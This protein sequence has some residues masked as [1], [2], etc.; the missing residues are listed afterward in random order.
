[1]QDLTLI[2]K[3][4]AITT[5]KAETSVQSDSSRF[6]SKDSDST[7]MLDTFL[8]YWSN[9]TD[10]RNR[11][12]RNYEY[13]IGNQ[14]Y[15]RINVIDK[16]GNNSTVTEDYYIRSNGRI[17]F[18]QNILQQIGKNIIGQYEL[19]PSQSIVKSRN[20]EDQKRSDM[21]SGALDEGM[22][23]NNIQILEPR[24]L[25]A[26]L[27]SGMIIS[28]VGWEYWPE[29][30]RSDL[31]YALV[32][33]TNIAFNAYNDPRGEGINFIGEIIDASIETV[34]AAFAKT[35]ADEEAIRSMFPN[36]GNKYS[37]QNSSSRTGTGEDVKNNDF[38]TPSD[39]SLCRVYACWEKRGEWRMREHDYLQGTLKVTKRTQKQIDIENTE[40]LRFCEQNGVQPDPKLH[41]IQSERRFEEFWYYKF[42]TANYECLAEGESPFEHQSHPYII[43]A[44]PLLNGRIWGYNEMLIDSQRQINRL[45]SLQDAILGGS[46]KNLLVIPEEALK[47]E[48]SSS[49]DEIAEEH[50]RIN[51]TIVLDLKNGGALPQTLT[52][53]AASLGIKDMVGSYITLIMNLSGISGAIQG[54]KANAGTP[55]SQ[56]AQEAQNSQINVLDVMTTFKFHKQLRDSKA[57]RVIRQY[58]PD[59]PLASNKTNKEAMMYKAEEVRAIKDV[60]V[61]VS[62]S[63]DTPIYRS[64]MQDKL[65]FF[66]EKGLMD[67]ETMAQLSDESWAEP[68]LAIIEKRKAE[69]PGQMTP[70]MAAQL[71]GVQGQIQQSDTRTP[72]QQQLVANTMR[73]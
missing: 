34:L 36:G 69:Q 49:L 64:I 12:N 73:G 28:K 2:K 72:E 50:S 57:L 21:L 32:N 68:L 52:G 70:E 55:S 67:I 6:K 35:E 62:Q 41:F 39:L 1:M 66:V 43:T 38:A 58:K 30:D 29:K 54:Q 71:Q 63:T 11:A 44:Y 19:S 46:A 9:L 23:I 14:W 15:E 8:T 10:T 20:R 17:P 65:M 53:S 42:L 60:D 37:K 59:G 31:K 48:Q 18:V 51:G 61:S 24:Q 40:R 25:E 13:Y 27:N 3:R 26:F 47:G 7:R 33:Y 4:K 16:Y 56:Y 45:L 22:D 5:R